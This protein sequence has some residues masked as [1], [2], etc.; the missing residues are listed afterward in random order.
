MFPDSKT[1]S[2]EISLFFFSKNK[3]ETKKF[4]DRQKMVLEVFIACFCVF[5]KKQ[6]NIGVRKSGCAKIKIFFLIK[7]FSFL[8]T[9]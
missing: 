1:W 9:N 5:K 2:F 8:V 6:F 4:K 7:R 3:I